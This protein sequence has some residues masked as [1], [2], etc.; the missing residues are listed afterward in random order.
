MPKIIT[1]G[2]SVRTGKDIKDV[3]WVGLE[4]KCYLCEARFELLEGDDIED[5]HGTT[6]VEV[7]DD[8]VHAWIKAVVVV[9]PHCHATNTYTATSD[10]PGQVWN[11]DTKLHRDMF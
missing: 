7:K 2:Y 1:P 4:C 6:Y 11:I 9:C 10:G 3:E 8:I 5:K